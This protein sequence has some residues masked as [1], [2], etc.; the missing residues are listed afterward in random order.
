MIADSV[1]RAFREQ[2]GPS[3]LVAVAPGRVNLIGEHTDYNEGFVLPVAIDRYVALAFAPNEDRALRGLSLDYGDRCS[4]RIGRFQQGG[5][6]AYVSSVTKVLEE[7]GLSLPGMDFV[8]R[9]D[10]PRGAGLA[11]SAALELAVARALHE[12]SETS[13]DGRRAAILCQ[14]AES[15]LVGLRCGVM[16]QM[17]ASISRAGSAMLLDCRSLETDYVPIP[18]GVAIV[19]LDTGTRRDLSASAYN[20]RRASCDAAV[21]AA[22]LHD[23]EVTALRDVSLE[24]LEG[25]RADMDEKTYRRARHVIEEN[26]RTLALAQALRAADARL[27]G[28]LMAGSHESLRSLYEVSSPALDR[29]VAQAVH[30]P[31]CLGARMTGAGFGGCAVALVEAE[32]VDAFVRDV[33]EGYRRGTAEPGAVYSCRPAGGVALIG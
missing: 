23:P 5:W 22:R 18:D 28:E 30:H 4:I 8:I 15:E 13:W 3:P 17:A 29:M 26:T 33:G 24:E 10:L 31:A 16:D 2:F 20:E 14:H 32:S 1:A 21:S 7:D 25:L 27:I 12:I 9:G 11:S 6:T 19:I